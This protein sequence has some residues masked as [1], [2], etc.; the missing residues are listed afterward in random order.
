M[1]KMFRFRHPI[2]TNYNRTRETAF[3]EGLMTTLFALKD[4]LIPVLAEQ[5]HMLAIET[6]QSNF[7]PVLKF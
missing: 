5:F 3:L 6:F 4:L 2:I 1:K 7:V